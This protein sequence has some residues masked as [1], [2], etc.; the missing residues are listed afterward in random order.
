MT[1]LILH[2][3][4]PKTGT[5]TVQTHLLADQPNFLGKEK[6][7]RCLAG[8]S[9][10]AKEMVQLTEA[11]LWQ[12]PSGLRKGVKGWRQRCDEILGHLRADSEAPSSLVL[13]EEKLATWPFTSTPGS[14]WPLCTGFGSCVGVP[15]SRPAPLV[16]L[17][18]EH[19][20]ELWPYGDIRI[21]LTIRNQADWLASHYSQLSS[22]IPNACQ[23]DF[24]AQTDAILERDDP[25]LDWAGWIEDLSAV[26]GAQNIATF[27]M[28][29][30]E[31]P[32]LWRAMAASFGLGEG[33]IPFQDLAAPSG[34]RAN[35]RR[36]REDDRWQVRPLKLKKTV[37]ASFQPHRWANNAWTMAAL[38]KVEGLLHPLLRATLDRHRGQEILLPAHLRQRILR[39]MEPAN[40]RLADYLKHDLSSL[41]YFPKPSEH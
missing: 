34:P 2:I 9:P 15:R 5:S 10:I 12:S 40:R 21:V 19:G 11:V 17:L 24:E 35:V 26:V 38:N 32:E 36:L 8:A 14:R 3:G 37:T 29:R 41:G 33:G 31:S 16:R 27:P 25:F 23:R 22:R 6:S 39:R 20:P 4:F 7:N 13:S 18:L 1:D 30:M 28:E